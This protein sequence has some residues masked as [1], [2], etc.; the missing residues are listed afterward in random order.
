MRGFLAFALTAI[1]TVTACGDAQPA[2]HLLT[3]ETQA[4]NSDSGGGSVSSKQNSLAAPFSGKSDMASQV[5]VDAKINPNLIFCPTGTWY[6]RAEKLCVN[7][8][9][10]FGPF[11][12]KMIELCKKYGGGESACEGVT[13][14]R[15]FAANLRTTATCPRGSTYDQNLQTCVEGSEV[16]GPFKVSDVDF[17]R[18]RGGGQVCETM[19]WSQS[20]FPL[21]VRGGSANRILLS[22]YSNR[23]NYD[24]VYDEVLQFY[25]PGRRNGCVAFM[26]TALRMSGTAVPLAAYIEGE[27]VSLVTKPFARYLQ[28]EL[29]WMKITSANNLQPGDVV[30]TEDDASYPGYPAHTYM[31]YGW[32]NQKAGIA[33][34][35]DNQDFI[36]ERNVFGYGTYNF[37]PFAYALRSPE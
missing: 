35:I 15:S 9:Q 2:L 7:E 27:S 5:S 33:W 26:S 37:T 22:Y 29:G 36:H 8:T 10:A 19:R 4:P 25:P 1:S 14:A 23:N 21:R 11:T 18:Q 32:S 30:L 34:V 31:F 24:E 20:F 13:W 6:S 16:Y 12:R 28:V 17:C 3:A